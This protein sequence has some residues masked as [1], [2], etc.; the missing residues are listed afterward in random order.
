MKTAKESPLPIGTYP[1]RDDVVR[2]VVV[3]PVQSPLPIG[4]YPFRDLEENE[5]RKGEAGLHCLS[6]LTPFGTAGH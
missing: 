6:A 4:T 2:R 1:F 3:A 5:G